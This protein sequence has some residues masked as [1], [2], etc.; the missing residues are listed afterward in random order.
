MSTKQEKKQQ[1]EDGST[2]ESSTATPTEEVL[3]E[4]SCKC[5]SDRG[6]QNRSCPLNPRNIT[7]DQIE[8]SCTHGRGVIF[9]NHN[10]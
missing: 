8:L 2:S 4:V 9:V 5:R 6:S 1:I 10:V 3:D 7:S